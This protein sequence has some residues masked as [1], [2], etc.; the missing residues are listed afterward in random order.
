MTIMDYVAAHY[1]IGNIVE[2]NALQHGNSS[3]AMLVES[4]LGKFV[5]RKLR[6]E[7]QAWIEYEMYQA[8]APAN[9][10][11]LM[12]QNNCA[13]PY[14]TYNNEIYNLQIYIEDVLPR[15]QINIDFVRL[16]QVIGLFHRMTSRFEVTSMEDRFEL[17]QLWREVSS[18]VLAS[19]SD[20]IRTLAQLTEQCL[21]FRKKNHS[22]IHGDLGIWNLLFTKESIYIID[23]GE[24]RKGDHHFDLAAILTS[25]IPS[26]THKQE[27]VGIMSDFEDGYV[28]ENANFSRRHLYEQIQVWMLRGLLAVI[29]ERGVA[30]S[31]IGYVERNLKLLT[32]FESILR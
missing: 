32:M 24:V 16:G 6:N 2:F 10:A 3:K 9:I 12:V 26:S 19:S 4:T 27:L 22:V 1:D 31:T 13:F 17:S 28:Q 20:Q 23:F 18:V 14:I 25:T 30:P 29:R 5:L 15:N 21:K 11:P 8:L 7:Q